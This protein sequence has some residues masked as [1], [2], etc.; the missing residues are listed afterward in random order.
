[1]LKI[2]N[3]TCGYEGRFFLR[4]INL[5]IEHKELM[6]I[7][8]PNGSGKTT[9]IRAITRLLRPKMGRIIFEEKDIWHTHLKEL[10]KRIAVVLQNPT[11]NFMTVQDFVLLGRIP[12]FGRLQFLE[13]KEDFQ[14]ANNAM[15]L[16]DT[17]KFKD[18][19]LDEISG[20]ERQLVFIARALAQQPQLLILDEPT[21]H[22][23]ITHQVAILDLIKK[24]NKELAL[25]VIMVLHDLNLASEYCQYLTLIN[26]GRIHKSGAPTEVLNYQI[27]EEVYKT[28]V[29]VEKNPVSSKPYI[30]L[31]SQEEREKRNYQIGKGSSRDL[32]CG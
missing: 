23:D 27:I 24:L 22:L 5:K 1:M 32:P 7:I 26:A 10:A 13:T 17:L 20:G 21:A 8:G 16:T 29:V 18:R 15:V 12:H 25:T 11:T 30:L 6:G 31:V 14:I 28:V 4:D 2:E 9:L 3:L 19:P